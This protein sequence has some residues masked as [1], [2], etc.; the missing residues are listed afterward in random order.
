M[1]LLFFFILYDQDIGEKNQVNVSL[2]AF[3][4]TSYHVRPHKKKNDV[5]N[6]KCCS[7]MFDNTCQTRSTL[8]GIFNQVS[9][10]L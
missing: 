4:C 10:V 1:E 2:M 9:F 6:M 5:E 8:F 3:F 7:I